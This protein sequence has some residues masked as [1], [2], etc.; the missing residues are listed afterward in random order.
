MHVHG[1]F[2]YLYVPYDGTQPW[3]RYLKLFAR[4]LDKALNVSLNK[5]NSNTQHVYKINLVSGIPMYGYHEKEEQFL[6]IFLYNPRM[7]KKAADLLLGGAVMN[8]AFQPHEAHIPYILQMFIDYNLYGMNMINV[9]AVKF[10]KQK[11]DEDESCY[12]PYESYD[13]MQKK[14]ESEESSPSTPTSL[15]DRTEMVTHKTWDINNIQ[16]ELLL[17]ES[18]TR[19]STCELECDVVAPDILNRQDVDDKIGINP[20]L[21]ALWE[22][23]KQRKRNIGETSQITPPDSQDY[24]REFSSN[25]EETSQ[26]TPGIF[27]KYGRDISDYSKEFLSNMGETSWITPGNSQVI[28]LRHLGL[29]Q[30]I[31]KEFPS[32]MG[33]TSQIT[34]PDS[35]EREN[36]EMSESDQ[37]LRLKYL[38]IIQDQKP[39][40]DSQTTDESQ[41]SVRD[42]SQASVLDMQLSEEGSNMIQ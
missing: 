9:C 12:L 27:K 6:K 15:F 20:G 17:D 10:R 13:R 26:I 8:K 3:D 25:M 14:K 34:P 39:Y 5:V 35:Q 24:S 38:Q 2:P 16:E 11:T 21:A 28:W 19:Q 7:V 36:I 41:G 23:E 32:N 40:I 42:N 31:P 18:I 37:M 29:L 30:G 22:D 4:S 1:V 33:E